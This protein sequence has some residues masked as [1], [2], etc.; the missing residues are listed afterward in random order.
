MLAEVEERACDVLVCDEASMVGATLD[1]DAREAL[2]GATILY[3]GDR[4]QLPPIDEPWG[5]DFERPTAAL[6]RIHRQAEG[7]PIIQVA[8]RLRT[9]EEKYPFSRYDADAG[10]HFAIRRDASLDDAARWLSDARGRSADA[11]LLTYTNKTRRA[12][13][14]RVREFLG[15]DALST[16]R[17]IPVVEGD[18]LLVRSNNKENGYWNGEV[19]T[20]ARSAWQEPTKLVGPHEVVAVWITG[21]GDDPVL[22]PMVAFGEDR[23]EFGAYVRTHERAW[24]QNEGKRAGLNLVNPSRALRLRGVP[25]RPLRAG[26]AVGGGLRRLGTR[27][28]GDVVERYRDRATLGVHGDHPREQAPDRRVRLVSVTDDF[29]G[30]TRDDARLMPHVSTNAARR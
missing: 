1:R 2:P 26:V 6:T 18:R 5:P 7:N 12:L 16:S 23:R 9:V 8:T 22:V 17:Q 15:L 11:T 27:L 20:V 13:N 25:D 10:G 4:E 19:L 14:L 21:R 24:E 29:V 3:V 30:A 28:L